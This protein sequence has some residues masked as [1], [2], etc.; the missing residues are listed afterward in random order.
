MRTRY[1]NTALMLE[2][3][4]QAWTEL[5]AGLPDAHALQSWAWGSFKSRWGWSALPLVFQ[6]ADEHE[7][8]AAALV[9]KRQIPY[10]PFCILYVPKGPVLDYHYNPLRRSMLAQLERVA[11]KERAIFIK[12]DPDV[13]K[14]LG[15]ETEYPVP[16]GQSLIE[17]L[18]DRGWCYSDDQIQFRNTVTL[19]LTCAEAE[20]LATMKQKTR[21]N[22]RLAE[23]KGV[24]V[25]AGS[26]ADFALV[27]QM[28]QETAARDGFA[29]RPT[30]Y[31]LDAWQT[32]YEAGLA[33]LLLAEYEADV[34]AAVI[35]VVGSGRCIYMYGASTDKERNRM[36]AYLLQWEAIRWAKAQGCHTYDFWGAPDEFVETD[37]LWGV[38]RFKKGFN[39]QVA[40][41]IGA[42]DYPAHPF[43]YRVYTQLL[44]KYLA[45]LRTRNNPQINTD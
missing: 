21:Y 11:Q 29:I 28:Y 30:A 22:I 1:H 35:L 14:S 41:H 18:K 23:R 10:T 19:N 37:Q 17:D 45:M 2:T 15:E 5:L 32:F 20:I 27:A 24:I 44:P 13:V 4:R 40:H 6:L 42:W 12:I 26:P 7:P 39:G 31:Y 16:I 38:W 3:D 25:R 33:H 34:L 9:L 8:P 36:P 43:W